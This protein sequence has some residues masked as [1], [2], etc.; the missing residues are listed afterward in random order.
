MPNYRVHWFKK[1]KKHDAFNEVFWRV[2]ILS[3]GNFLKGSNIIAWWARSE[4]PNWSCQA[5]VSLDHLTISCTR[6][7]IVISKSNRSRQGHVVGVDANSCLNK[8]IMGSVNWRLVGSAHITIRQASDP[9]HVWLPTTS[10]LE[11]QT[12]QVSCWLPTLVTRDV[13]WAELICHE[14]LQK[15]FMQA[16]NIGHEALNAIALSFRNWTKHMP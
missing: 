14:A 16:Q 12:D 7:R 9:R 15:L 1:K 8:V 10:T 3:D 13:V 6:N 4:A 2:Q 5:E 11:R